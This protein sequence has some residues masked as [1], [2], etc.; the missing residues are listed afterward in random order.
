MRKKSYGK[1][2]VHL[3]TAE[4]KQVCGGKKS[5]KKQSLGRGKCVLKGDRAGKCAFFYAKSVDFSTAG[6]YNISKKRGEIMSDKLFTS[7]TPD[8]AIHEMNLNPGPFAAIKNGLKNV[9]MRLNDE[10][11]QSIKKGDY[12][13]F[14][15]TESGEQL[16]VKVEDKLVYRDFSQLYAHH[17]KTTIGYTADQE[18]HPDDM[19]E[20]YTRE[21]IEKYGALAIVLS[22]V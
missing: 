1:G 7:L 10:R 19:L 14:T 3:K 22:L 5:K 18:A 9:E 20:Y 2:R 11:R 8:A 13:R 21:K 16:L 6:W 15:H 4:T 17:D 12:I